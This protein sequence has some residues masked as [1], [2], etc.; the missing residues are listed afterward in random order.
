VTQTPDEQL[1]LAVAVSWIPT[2]D[3]RVDS[4]V[5]MVALLRDIPVSD[6]HQVFEDV[7]GRLQQTLAD[8]SGQ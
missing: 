3:I 2:D 5:E 4:A 7:H 6:H 1:P 8:A